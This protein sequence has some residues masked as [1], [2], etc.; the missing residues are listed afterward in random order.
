MRLRLPTFN[1][2]LPIKDTL[3][4][5]S[6]ILRTRCPSAH[7]HNETTREIAPSAVDDTED[8]KHHSQAIKSHQAR[9]NK[10]HFDT[11]TLLRHSLTC[12]F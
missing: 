3:L 4:R 6:T 1:S 9:V 2:Q 11:Q 5:Y 10:V 7:D 12:R 8:H